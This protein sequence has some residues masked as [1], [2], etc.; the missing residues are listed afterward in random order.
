MTSDENW[1]R[2]QRVAGYAM[3]LG[4]LVSVVTEAVGGPAASA[5][6]IEAVVA[7]APFPAV[8]SLVHARRQ[9]QGS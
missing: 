8:Y 2:T 6:G 4:G 7:S 5:V 3:V 1:A 9:D